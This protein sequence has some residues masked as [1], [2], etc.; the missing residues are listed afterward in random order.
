MRPCRNILDLLK[1]DITLYPLLNEPRNQ[2]CTIDVDNAHVGQ[3][4][5]VIDQIEELVSGEGSTSQT[6]NE[7]YQTEWGEWLNNRSVWYEEHSPSR[8]VGDHEQ[9]GDQCDEQRPAGCT[10]TAT[11]N[12]TKQ[13]PE[14]EQQE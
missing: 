6:D 2:Y 8:T 7:E 9:N 3:D 4:Q 12:G 1:D 13:E 10:I 14:Q 5:L 11:L